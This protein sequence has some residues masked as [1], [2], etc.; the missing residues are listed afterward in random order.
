MIE[1]LLKS[2]LVYHSPMFEAWK[3]PKRLVEVSCDVTQHLLAYRTAVRNRTNSSGMR[4]RTG[5]HSRLPCMHALNFSWLVVR[6]VQK[7]YQNW[8]HHSAL[9]LY[10]G[11]FASSFRRVSFPNLPN[12][13]GKNFSMGTSTPGRLISESKIW[14]EFPFNLSE[15]IGG[16]N[17]ENFLVPSFKTLRFPLHFVSTVLLLC[18]WTGKY[19]CTYVL[20][21]GSNIQSLLPF[22]LPSG[23]CQL[24]IT[25]IVVFRVGCHGIL[26]YQWLRW[27]DS[28][29]WNACWV[30][31]ISSNNSTS[32]AVHLAISTHGTSARY[33]SALLLTWSS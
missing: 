3:V 1:L 25:I 22:A 27:C 11:N 10:K 5:Q 16:Q 21:Q 26:Q 18:T 8:R 13:L 12:I 4:T 29:A 20:A 30:A 31:R 28:A 24:R 14:W 17:T 33:G 15:N 19:A 32:C 23:K 9:A 7:L 2:F 6:S